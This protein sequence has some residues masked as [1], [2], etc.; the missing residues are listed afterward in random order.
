MT[1]E[2]SAGTL[3]VKGMTMR[4][5][6][7][8]AVDNLDLIARSGEITAVI[9]PNGAGK[10]TAFNCVTGFY[11]PTSGEVSVDYG[12][13]PKRVDLMPG[14]RI[15][16]QAR[17]SRTFQ[18]IRLFG[19]MTALENLL[20]AQHRAMSRSGLLQIA[21]LFGLPAFRRAEKTAID[22]A[23]SWLD[24]MGL[25][26][27]ANDDAGTLPYG[28]QRRLEIARAMC[29]DPRF[30]CLDEPAAG[31]NPKESAALA[32]LLKEL[33]VELRLGILLI[34]HDMSVVMNVSDKIAVLE[35]GKKIAE[36]TPAEIR[37]DPKVIKAYLGETS[38]EQTI[39]AKRHPRSGDSKASQPSSFLELRGLRAGYGAIEVLHDI[40][41]SVQK[42]E[43]VTLLG[44]NGAGKSTLLRTMF[45]APTAQ[46]GTIH[47]EGQEITKLPAHQ[48]A[49]LG[50]AHAPEGR[51]IMPQ[52]T[53]FENLQLGASVAEE[54]YFVADL[55]TVYDLFPRL[56]ERSRQRAGTLSGGE[57]QML[58]IGRALMQRPT[59]L[60]LDEPSLGLAPII[61]RQIFQAISDINHR[62]GITV[63]LVEQNA[64]Q[65]LSIADRG[66]VLQ[67][68][69]I[70]HHGEAETLMNM[71]E[72]RGAYLEG[73]SSDTGRVV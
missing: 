46:K 62:Q 9:G 1:I 11:S 51:R 18:N 22:K 69:R 26:E 67:T 31:L 19:G 59:L 53:V 48:V 14:H 12:D 34:E 57:Q 36:G 40:D 58:A 25:G 52:M 5:G 28:Q 44:A 29:L 35:Y 71:P 45:G 6:G 54:K 33:A 65:A 20:V 63:L 15:A 21:G 49:R 39:R 24:R 70:V 73:H 72:I 17:V 16:S 27:R 38:D 56:K 60:L 68:G 3:S 41:L 43:I 8:V 13:G 4:F 42:G 30:L 32:D 23:M 66:Y 7:I 61:I 37:D 64:S 55:Q 2:A 10:T 50:I 47:F